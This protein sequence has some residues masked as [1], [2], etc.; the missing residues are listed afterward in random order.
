MAKEIFVGIDISKDQLDVHVLPDNM[1][2]S[3]T[4][5]EKGLRLLVKSLKEIS[6]VLIVLKATGGYQNFVA[7]GLGAALLPFSV[8]NPAR[9]R[10]FARAIGKLAK[11]DALDAYVIARYAEAIKPEPQTLPREEQT[12]MKELINRRRQLVKMRTAEKNHLSA[13]S[14]ASLRARI[15]SFLKKIDEEITAI[16]DD[17]DAAI[18]SCPDWSE[19]DQLLQSVPGVG[20]NTSRTLLSDL[21]ELGTLNRQ[22]IASLVGVAPMNR[23]SGLMRGKRK[24]TGGRPSVRNML[25]MA[26]VASLRFNPKIGPF[27]RRLREAGKPAKVAIVAAMRKLLIMLNA[28][29]KSKT[30]FSVE[31]TRTVS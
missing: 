23:D 6:P 2:F 19:R 28:I 9:I 25:Y 11:T 13:V 16:N 8:V 20:P 22:K 10:H 14:T 12:F 18:R 15:K 27:Y 17:L 26:T 1:E 24:I 29:L 3:C 4:R 5:D 21:P 30:T 7:A 31:Y